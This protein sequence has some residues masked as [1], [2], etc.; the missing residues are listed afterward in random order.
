MLKG[1]CPAV[2][3]R[4]KYFRFVIVAFWSIVVL[5]NTAYAASQTSERVRY[6]DYANDTTKITR[7]LGE[8]LRNDPGNPGAR[9]EMFGRMFL[10]TPYVAHTLE[11]DSGMPEVITVNVD[12]LD[13]TT[14]VETVAAMAK[15][16]GEGRSS[17]R[18]FVYNLENLRYRGG[19]MTDY[20]SRLHYIAD[21][22]V[23][24]SYRGNVKD[25]T[26]MFPKVNYV[27][28][29]IDFMSANRDKYT[30]L[31]DSAQYQRIR[32][33]ENGYR[34][35]RYPYIKTIDLG[36]KATK[37]AF[38]SGDMVALTSNLKN[39][40]VTHLGIVVIIDGEPHLMHAS[41][42]LGKV[43]ITTV[44]LDEF[45]RRNRNL[46]GLRVFRLLE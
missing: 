39:L 15:T 36:N 16:V 27:T 3:L 5:S 2:F 34:N 14:F 25:V 10:D 37:A 38:R 33:I 20:G 11:V 9:I 41:S 21:W 24:N 31:T 40:D 43:V 12:E 6:H 44:P 46:T 17:W 4:S 32:S 18:D 28:K 19:E 1:T 30:A 22:I 7:M 45:M 35:H 13:C 23:D 8:V 29:S 42:S 26:P